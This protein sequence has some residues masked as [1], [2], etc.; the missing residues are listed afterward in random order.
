MRK[1]TAIT[2]GIVL[3]AAAATIYGIRH[4]PRMMRQVEKV[5][6]NFSSAAGVVGEAVENLKEIDW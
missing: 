1:M 6:D 4:N 2:T 5:K 3:G